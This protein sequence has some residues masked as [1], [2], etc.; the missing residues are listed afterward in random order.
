MALCGQLSR[1]Y[2]P[3]LYNA[4]DFLLPKDTK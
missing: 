3:C 1:D 4:V 2:A